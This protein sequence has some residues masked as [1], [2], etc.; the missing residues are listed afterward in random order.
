MIIIIKSYVDNIVI[1]ALNIS[2]L[3]ENNFK[4][5]PK[6]FYILQRTKH[7]LAGQGRRE[8]DVSRA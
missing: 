8:H 4:I 7:P 6:P 5:Q 3:I 2:F 1:I